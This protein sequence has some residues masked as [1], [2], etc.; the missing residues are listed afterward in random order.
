MR[1][2]NGNEAEAFISESRFVWHQKFELAPG[3]FT[4]GTNPIASI[5]SAANL[6]GVANKSVLDIGTCNGAV[7]FEMER[8]GA[9]RMV[10]VDIYD[11]QWFGFE[12]IREF[13]GSRAEFVQASTYDLDTTLGGKFDIVFFLGVLYHLR[14]P[15]LA[16]DVVRSLTREFAV[17]ESQVC[18]S[19][20]G[21][22]ADEP[23]VRFYRG[24][25][26]SGDM[27]NWF[28]PTRRALADWLASSG[29]EVVSITGDLEADRAIVSCRPTAGDPEYLESYERPLRVVANQRFGTAADLQP[30]DRAWQQARD[31]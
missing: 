2:P 7:C 16:I 25:E 30:T 29:F 1:T 8:R 18:D 22:Q 28:S 12:P 26:L 9:A 3:V 24:R 4:P 17:V 21:E 20:V 27:S 6:P 15:L 14:H 19:T 10:G 31:R 13:L 11:D 23:L 5:L